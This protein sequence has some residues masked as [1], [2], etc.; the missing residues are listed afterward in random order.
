MTQSTE[1]LVPWYPSCSLAFVFSCSINHNDVEMSFVVIAPVGNYP[2]TFIRGSSGSV[3][4]S[5]FTINDSVRDLACFTSP[6]LFL[7][8]TYRSFSLPFVLKGRWTYW[9][10]TASSP[11]III[12]SAAE[13]CLGVLQ[14]RAKKQQINVQ[15]SLCSFLITPKVAET[16]KLNFKLYFPFKF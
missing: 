3:I 1:S 6:L 2:A 15:D 8:L 16:L 13:I 9:F 12:W 5:R 11:L 7:L 10:Y 14:N 4:L